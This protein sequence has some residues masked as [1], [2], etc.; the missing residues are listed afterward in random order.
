MDVRNIFYYRFCKILQSIC[1]IINIITYGKLLECWA[2]DHKYANN[3]CPHDHVLLEYVTIADCQ[4]TVTWTQLIAKEEKTD[5][6]EEICIDYY[7]QFHQKKLHK[8]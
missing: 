2:I 3:S 4:L 7:T 6:D 8:Q 5:T 1:H